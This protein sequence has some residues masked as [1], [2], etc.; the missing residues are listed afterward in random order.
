M[1]PE[2]KEN[3]GHTEQHFTFRKNFQNTETY[4]KQGSR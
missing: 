1:Q 4:A 2:F 3:A